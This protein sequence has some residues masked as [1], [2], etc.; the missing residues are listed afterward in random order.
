MV[1]QE[2]NPTVFRRKA[3]TLVELL[4][5]I[6][7]IALLI[8]ILLPALN[9][10]RNAAQLVAC[11]S[12]LRQIGIGFIQ[13]SNDN[14]DWWPVLKYDAS[15]VVSGAV[16]GDTARMCEG[17]SLEMFLSKYTGTAQ[18]WSR[19]TASKSV[20]G[21]IWI[22]PSSGGTTGPGTGAPGSLK[23]GYEFDGN[24]N[25]SGKNCYAGL[26][27]Q[28]RESSHYTDV[29]AGLPLANSTNRWKRNFYRSVQLQMPQQWC[30]RRLTGGTSTNTLSIESFHG[31]K[32]GRP[33]L[34]V[35]GHVSVLRKAAYA[36]SATQAMTNA[37]LTVHQIKGTTNGDK[38]AI[39]E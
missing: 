8:S 28:E 10:A 24:A 20:V 38:F 4:V 7:I 30:S 13:Y 26:Y 35:D 1:P 11:S 31:A 5:V 6:G 3:F 34:F 14:K 18:V 25:N 27:Y 19:V 37:N 33:T 21:G 29:G 17:Y 16:V 2:A 15:T 12:N 36:G 39:S 23:K 9:K 32:A 22:C